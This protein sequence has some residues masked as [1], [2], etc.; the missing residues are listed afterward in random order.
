MRETFEDFLKQLAHGHVSFDQL[1][2]WYWEELYKRD[3]KHCWC[4]YNF[5]KNQ[6]EC[7][8]CGEFKEIEKVE[9]P[10]PPEVDEEDWY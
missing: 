4:I 3:H 9:P 10:P 2:E 7:C 5:K 6:A 8:Q 1:A